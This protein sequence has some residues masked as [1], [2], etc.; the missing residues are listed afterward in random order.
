MQKTEFPP[1]SEAGIDGRWSAVSP[2][3]TIDFVL[4]A[5][6]SSDCGGV[7]WNL[8]ILGRETPDGPI[9]E[10]GDFRKDFPQTNDA[11][12]L[13]PG[14]DPWADFAQALLASNEFHFI[15]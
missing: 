5:P 9:R 6:T 14:G 1:D 8:R 12:P 11:P 3:D 2:G 10:V 13:P 4:R 7:A 15:D